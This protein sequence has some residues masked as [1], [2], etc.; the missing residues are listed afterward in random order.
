M[1]V[2]LDEEHALAATGFRGVIR[3]LEGVD[4]EV[5][6]GP[7]TP[8]LRSGRA[9]PIFP[10]KLRWSSGDRS[11]LGL[12]AEGCTPGQIAERLGLSEE[13]AEARRICLMEQLGLDKM[14]AEVR[15]ARSVGL[16]G[17]GS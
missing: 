6:I 10:K 5:I 17:A 8:T 9:T 1:V 4:V 2:W 16:V 3:N 11:L 12:I 14:A 15:Y 7:W 13:S